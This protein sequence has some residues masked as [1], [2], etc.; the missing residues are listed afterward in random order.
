[1]TLDAVLPLLLG[2][3]IGLSL[4]L[5]GGG[6]AIF[7]VPL[8]I[9]G[10]GLSATNAI[11]VSLVTVAVTACF[12]FV[13][14]ARVQQVEF[15]TGIVFGIAGIAGAPLGS[16]IASQLSEVVLMASFS[17]LMFIIAVKMWTASIANEHRPPEKSIEESGA[18]CSR[19]ADGKL[20]ITSPC[21]LLLG[22]I[23]FGAGVLA[24]MFGVGGG[25]I[26]V[27]SLVSF[28][29][30][31]MQKAIGTSLLV[32]TIVGVS[33]TASQLL[34]GRELPWQ[35]TIVFTLGSLVGLLLGTKL[36]TRLHGKT[37]QRLFAVAIL[38]VAIF[39]VVRSYG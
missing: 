17:L 18:V 36:S 8:L 9:Y 14:R 23:G 11:S 6:G 28:A 38:L 34:A 30:M 26:I 10:L 5:T 32:I 37:L 16:L 24:G 22:S 7:A 33:G 29:S 19:S 35:V 12:G 20:C 2:S 31:G 1:M 3:V 4:G 21:A 15:S 27:P 13:Q 25:F 39:V